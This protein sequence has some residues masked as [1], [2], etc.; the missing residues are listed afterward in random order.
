MTHPIALSVLDSWILIGLIV[1]MA[2]ALTDVMY[3]SG[4]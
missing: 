4:K 3:G 1:I 2:K